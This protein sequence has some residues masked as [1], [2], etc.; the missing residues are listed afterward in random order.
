MTWPNDLPQPSAYKIQPVDDLTDNGEPLDAL[1]SHD[2]MLV[3]VHTPIVKR[4]LD[5]MLEDLARASESVAVQEPAGR[6]D[7]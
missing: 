4:Y 7:R 3:Y 1:F 2:E 6:D 5:K